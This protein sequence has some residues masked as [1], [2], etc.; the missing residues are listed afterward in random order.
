MHSTYPKIRVSRILVNQSFFTKTKKAKSRDQADC[1]E[2]SEI[3]L[4][5]VRVTRAVL[6]CEDKT[7]K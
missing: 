1:F 3:R 2:L 5:R 7:S 4:K 6:L